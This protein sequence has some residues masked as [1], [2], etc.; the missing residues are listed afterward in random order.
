MAR[1]TLITE[2]WRTRG[3]S[4]GTGALV[5]LVLLLGPEVGVAVALLEL[6]WEL[7]RCG[8]GSRTMVEE[9]GG[10]VVGRPG[11]GTKDGVGKVQEKSTRQWA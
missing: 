10:H 3:L 1:H 7:R 5:G 4:S 11:R 9:S 8:M 6:R 2:T